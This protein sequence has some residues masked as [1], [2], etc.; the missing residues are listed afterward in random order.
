VDNGAMKTEAIV[1]L[2]VAA[3]M[4]KSALDRRMLALRPAIRR[5]ETCGRR[6][7]HSCHSCT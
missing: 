4:V 2:T 6:L 7:R 3:L 1:A 5:C